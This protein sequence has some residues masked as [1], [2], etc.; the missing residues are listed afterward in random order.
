MYPQFIKTFSK[1]GIYHAL[2]NT[3][4]YE[5]S[6]GSARLSGTLEEVTEELTRQGW[7]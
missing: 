4:N 2:F 7:K 6:F 5:Y 3:G 1:S